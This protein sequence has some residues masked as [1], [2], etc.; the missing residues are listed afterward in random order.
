MKATLLLAIFI[1]N[2]AACRATLLP[3][4][5]TARRGAA[6]REGFAAMPAWGR[7]FWADMHS[8]LVR[9][10]V[11]Y[12]TNNAE[13]DWANKGGDYRPYVFA[14]LGAD[15]PVW[16]GNL[17]DKQ[18]G[19]S[20]TLPFMVDVWLDMFERT[21]APVINTGYRFGA[22]ELG[23]IHRLKKPLSWSRLPNWWWLTLHSYAIRLTPLKHECTHIG[24]ELTIHR[25][26]DSAM[27]ITRINVS[28][29]Y[30]EL[31]FTLNDPDG[32][33]Q[34]NLG[35]KGGILVLHHP[36]EGW[37]S[38]LPEEGDVELVQPVHFPVEMYAQGQYQTNTSRCG[39]QGIASMEIRYRSHYRYPFSHTGG[40]GD[41]LDRHPQIAE[42]MLKKNADI[43]SNTV[44]GIRYNNP[45]HTGYF[46][47][48][49]ISCRYY[50]GINPYGQFRSQLNYNQW[51]VTL[52]FE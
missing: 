4:T 9:A 10:E 50:T 24:D 20:V 33:R 11:A 32:S 38:I 7:P 42:L 8:T 3:D 34:R 18:Y 45:K 25:K 26:D 44:V 17:A 19:V 46:S 35:V 48:I 29:N 5:A 1:C 28:Y 51:G 15:L 16:S 6:F 49:G 41:Y 52:I 12:A 2:A 40:F 14:N 30:A 23:F 47:K 27:H 43:C 37:Y 36:K 39:L 21:T 13:Y 31:Q 22:L